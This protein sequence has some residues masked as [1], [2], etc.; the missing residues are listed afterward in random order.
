[1]AR[2][3]SPFVPDLGHG[4]SDAPN[5]LEALSRAAQ[6]TR[7]ML[8]PVDASRWLTLGLVAWLAS[9][10]EAGGSWLSDPSGGRGSSG[11][12]QM[13]Q[14]LDRHLGV[15]L[16][17]AAVVVVL[18]TVV[19]AVLLWVNTRARFVFVDDI[20]HDRALVEEPW[21]RYAEHAA[22]LFRV[23][24]AL[25]L[26]SLLITLLALGLGLWLAWEDLLVAR[27]GP[28]AVTGLMIGFVVLLLTVPL[29]ILGALLEDFVLV[30]ML[31]HG[32]DVS[33]AWQRTKEA[34]R[35]RVGSVVLFYLVKLLVG[36]GSTVV[37][38]VATCLTCC[39]A[40]LPYIGTV[41]LLPLVVFRRAYVLYF[42]QQLGVEWRLFPEEVAPPWAVPASLH[43]PRPDSARE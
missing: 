25:M 28:A 34:L 33:A 7:R 16:L 36:V 41:A 15:V 4:P 27:F 19:G 6:H 3:Q 12:R 39:V 29:A 21:R 13:M 1:M 30:A 42:V 23:R 20:V 26:V 18:A 38:L 32:P 37:A 24:L 8:F 22:R 43:S 14:L 10:G 9:F 2:V 31:L 5:A 40:A 35:G 11:L 17:V